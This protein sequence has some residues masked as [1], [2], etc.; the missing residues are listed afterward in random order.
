M[1]NW[2]IPN[3]MKVFNYGEGVSA[4]MYTSKKF[5]M[6]SSGGGRLE[7]T[8]PSAT[9]SVTWRAGMAIIMLLVRNFQK[10]FRSCC[11]GSLISPCNPPHPA[12]C[13]SSWWWKE[14]G[15]L[16]SCF[17]E[18]LMLQTHATHSYSVFIQQGQYRWPLTSPYLNNKN[19]VHLLAGLFLQNLTC[20]M[21][22]KFKSD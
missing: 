15:N 9:K 4:N 19:Y 3:W 8:L 21:K 17:L 7:S 18:S 5:P 14:H 16:T 12:G 20:M 1:P 6:L 11:I 10:L 13:S 2:I 22:N